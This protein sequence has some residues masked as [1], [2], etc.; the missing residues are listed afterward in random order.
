MK[1]LSSFTVVIV[2]LVLVYLAYDWCRSTIE[3]GKACGKLRAEVS[4]EIYGEYLQGFFTGRDLSSH[5]FQIV[6]P[7][8]DKGEEAVYLNRLEN[9]TQLRTEH[10]HNAGYHIGE[11]YQEI[12]SDT[13]GELYRVYF[14]TNPDHNANQAEEWL[15]SE[16]SGMSVQFEHLR[17]LDRIHGRLDRIWYDIVTCES[18]EELEDVET[19]YRELL[20]EYEAEM[21]REI[22]R[23]SKQN[24]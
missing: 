22:P 11:S 24:G 23:V 5:C 15:A 14:Q 4:K 9:M 8:L 21:R 12:T 13:V 3:F 18:M 6:R 19:Q 10:R 17:K 16:E 1:K 2:V 20:A 7:L